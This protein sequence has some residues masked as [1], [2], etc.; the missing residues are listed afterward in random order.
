LNFVD[1]GENLVMA[2]DVVMPLDSPIA[3]VENEELEET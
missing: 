2:D 3:P 1:A